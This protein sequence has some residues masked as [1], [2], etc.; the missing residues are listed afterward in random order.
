MERERMN[1]ATEQQQ[2]TTSKD[3]YM[4]LTIKKKEQ[5]EGN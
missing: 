4:D 1:I 5:G 2:A 3:I